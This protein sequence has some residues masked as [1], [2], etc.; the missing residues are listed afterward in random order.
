KSLTLDNIKTT[1]Q[2]TK[3]TIDPNNA[4]KEDSSGFNITGINIPV[5]QKVTITFEV[6]KGT[7]ALN[8]ETA[9]NHVTVSDDLDNHPDTE[10][11]LVDST[12]INLEINVGNFYTTAQINNL[13]GETPANPGDDSTLPLSAATIQRALSLTGP[14]FREIAPTSGT[15][16]QV[17]HETVIT[18]TGKDVEG[19]KAGELR[20]TIDD[21]DGNTP[22]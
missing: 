9:I 19:S 15:A 18:N 14:T 10:N 5:G 6:K 16:G 11:T 7:A 3:G 8:P 21:N 2:A 22:D 12:N 17:T 13:N 20:F 4:G 1:G